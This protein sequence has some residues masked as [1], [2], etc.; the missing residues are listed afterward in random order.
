MKLGR[1]MALGGAGL[2][3]VAAHLAA[4]AFFASHDPY[5]TE[6]LPPCPILAATGWQC[7]GCGGIR[8]AYSLLHGDLIGSAVMNPL[9]LVLYVAGALIVASAVV[10]AKARPRL[11]NGLAFA[12]LALVTAG[13]LYTGI[14]RNLLVA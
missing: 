13:G 6:I 9:V 2:G 8:A 4:A 10:T 7:P 12:A 1:G 5:S 11:G 14:V 3:F